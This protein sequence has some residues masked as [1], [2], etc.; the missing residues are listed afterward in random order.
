MMKNNKNC[1]EFSDPSTSSPLLPWFITGLAD[2]EGT[3][4]I[5]IIKRSTNRTG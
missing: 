5:K 1:V 4:A 2:G 3:F